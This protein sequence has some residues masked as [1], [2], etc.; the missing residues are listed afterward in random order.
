MDTGAAS[1]PNSRTAW[2]SDC[3]IPT[4]TAFP[5]LIYHGRRQEAGGFV[6]LVVRGSLVDEAAAERKGCSGQVMTVL[7]S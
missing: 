3:F 6:D 2:P 4:P 7:V 5:T 1:A